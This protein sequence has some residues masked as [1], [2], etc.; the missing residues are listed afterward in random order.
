M[1]RL[2]KVLVRQRK[3]FATPISFYFLPTEWRKENTEKL[4]H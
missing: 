1:N 4:T 3:L 2:V